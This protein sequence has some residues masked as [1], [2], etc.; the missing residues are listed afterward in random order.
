MNILP[1]IPGEALKL[2]KQAFLEEDTTSVVL[3]QRF[4]KGLKPQISCQI[5]LR[6]NPETLE[7]A[8]TD[9]I[10]FLEGKGC[11]KYKPGP[12]P[13]EIISGKGISICAISNPTSETKI[14]VWAS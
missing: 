1:G 3:L 11:Y 7:Q 2:F 8:I 12:F 13:C 6:K 14:V 5:L 10:V 4:L 9:A